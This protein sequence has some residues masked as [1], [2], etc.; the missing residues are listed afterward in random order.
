MTC[1]NCRRE[2]MRTST[3]SLNQESETQA[4]RTVYAKCFNCGTQY[5]WQE[6]WAPI[7]QGGLQIDGSPRIFTCGQ[8]R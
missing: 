1:P 2:I 4:R 7:T 5:I 6:Y 3:S 8:P